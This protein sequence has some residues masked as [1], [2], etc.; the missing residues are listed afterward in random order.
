M[1][2]PMHQCIPVTRKKEK[3]DD[4]DENEDMAEEFNDAAEAPGAVCK[5]LRFGFGF[6]NHRLILDEQIFLPFFYIRYVFQLIC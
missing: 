1:I 5:Y 4:S 6:S 2:H 3:K